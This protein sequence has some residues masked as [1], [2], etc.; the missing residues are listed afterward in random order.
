M[1]WDG[2]GWDGMVE[3]SLP[4]EL[5]ADISHEQLIHAPRRHLGEG[6]LGKYVGK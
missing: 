2:M 6:E 3:L 4:V 5:R 1:G